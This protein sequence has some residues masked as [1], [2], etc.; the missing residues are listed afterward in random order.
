MVHHLEKFWISAIAIA[1]IRMKYF[2]GVAIA[3][4]RRIANQG[5]GPQCALV[6][7]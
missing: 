1:D 3:V 5:H 2:G 4:H 7:V 6:S